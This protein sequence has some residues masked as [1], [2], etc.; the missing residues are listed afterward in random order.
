MVFVIISAEIDLSFGFH[1]GLFGRH[2]RRF[3]YVWFHFPILFNCLG[4]VNVAGLV[5]WFCLTAGGL[6]YQKSASFIVTLRVYVGVSWHFSRF[7]RRRTVAPRPVR[8]L[9][10]GQRYIPSVGGSV[11]LVVFRFLLA[12]VTLAFQAQDTNTVVVNSSGQK[13]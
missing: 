7:N 3:W 11:Q 9:L 10:L 13:F 8:W 12:R 2:S 6:A 4:H 5:A 1:D